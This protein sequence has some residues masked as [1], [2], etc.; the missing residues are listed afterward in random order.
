MAQTIQRTS[1]KWKFVIVV[2]YLFT[3]MAI[4]LFVGGDFQDAGKMLLAGIG[5]HVLGKLGAWWSNG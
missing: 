4:A 2:S 3:L 5:I 1:K